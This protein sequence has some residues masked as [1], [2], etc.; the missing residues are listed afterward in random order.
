MTKQKNQTRLLNL[1]KEI[2]TAI[3]SDFVFLVWPDKVQHFPAR[4]WATPQFQKTIS[5]Y[6]TT[7]LYTTF[8]GYLVAY[9]ENNELILILP[10][11]KQ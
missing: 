5:E 11:M 8:N 9:E 3:S 4:N 10:G 1:P 7:P 2:T 6:L